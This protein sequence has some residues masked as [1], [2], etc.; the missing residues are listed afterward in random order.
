MVHYKGFQMKAFP[1]LLHVLARGF[2]LIPLFTVAACGTLEA[3]VQVE[4]T[5]HPEMVGQQPD[6]V[7]A[8]AIVLRGYS[9]PTLEVT[10]DSELLLRL[11]WE[12]MVEPETP[13]ALGITLRQTGP[14][15]KLIALTS[16]SS[17]S[18]TVARTVSEHTLYVPRD[19]AGG[20]YRLQIRLYHPETG[21]LVYA[22]PF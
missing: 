9:L 16:D 4:T 3:S 7:F 14:Q 6:F 13:Y 17:P 8:D 1:D 12:V 21:T 18:W 15:G 11:Y 10:T 19:V 2:W 22:V 20:N 5:A